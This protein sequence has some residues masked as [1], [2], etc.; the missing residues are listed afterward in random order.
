VIETTLFAA[1]MASARLTP[2]LPVAVLAALLATVRLPAVAAPADH[3]Q[4]P[5][6]A[7]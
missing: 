5:A 7:A 1:L 3:E 4:T 6:I 2:P